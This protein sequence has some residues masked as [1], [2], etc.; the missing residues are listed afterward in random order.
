M[1][2]PT[3]I[4]LALTGLSAGAIAD[5][6]D[7]DLSYDFLEYRYQEAELDFNDF[8]ID[9]DG[10]QFNGALEISDSLH[11]F[12][13]FDKLTFDDDVEL[14]TRVLGIGWAFDLSARTDIV[15]RAGV[16]DAEF[17]DPQFR[18]TADGAVFSIG[19]RSFVRD[20]IELY[21]NLNRF[22]FDDIDDEESTTIGLDFYFSESF[23]VGP[24]INWI[25]DT[26]TWSLGGKFYF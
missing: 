16:V 25:E 11:L 26:T 21:G 10:Y 19:V 5:H 2:K 4:A 17:E 12:G 7:S 6:R 1:H 3:L 13:G 15:L 9:G 14:Q 8:E 20:D 22:Q 24:A 18:Q 23:A